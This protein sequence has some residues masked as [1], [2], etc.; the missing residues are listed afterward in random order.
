MSH[1]WQF[2]TSPVFVLPNLGNITETYSSNI[3]QGLYIIWGSLYIY[4]LFDLLKGYIR[5]V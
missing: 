1:A 2:L 3:V 4:T 5:K